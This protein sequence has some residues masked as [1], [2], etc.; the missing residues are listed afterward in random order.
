MCP[1]VGLVGFGYFI[2]RLIQKKKGGGGGGGGSGWPQPTGP[3]GGG[4]VALEDLEA[5]GARLSQV[6]ETLIRVEHGLRLG[7]DDD[8]RALLNRATAA[9]YRA[10]EA[11]ARARDGKGPLSAVDSALAEAESTSR[12]AEARVQSVFGPLAFSGQGERVGCYFCA[13]PLA[14]SDY[15]V[16]VPLKRGEGTDTV[17][18]CRACANLVAAGQTPQVKV[19]QEGGRML[20]WSELPDYDPYIHRHRPYVGSRSVPVYDFA[21]QRSIGELAAMAAGGAVVGGLAMYAVGKLL[22]LDGARESAMARAAAEEMARRS[23][24]HHHD[25]Y[26]SSSSIFDS[27]RSSSTEWR[28]RS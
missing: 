27:N 26:S 10:Q 25:T 2:Y 20:H 7:E 13:R 23:H 12:E 28:D 22:D 6:S 21:P 16:Q 11:L 3:G 17:L 24:R 9:E 8:A 18:A 1:V 5:R 4:P 15:R 14:N 19:R